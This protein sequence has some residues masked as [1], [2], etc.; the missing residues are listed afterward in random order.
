MPQH[1]PTVVFKILQTS[2]CKA[3]HLV[4][5]KKESQ[6]LWGG[7]LEGKMGPNIAVGSERFQQ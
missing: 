2:L 5:G 7:T 1:T 4:N 6:G 3:A